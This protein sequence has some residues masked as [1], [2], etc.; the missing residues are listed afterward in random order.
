MIDRA[1]AL[2]TAAWWFE[3]LEPGTDVPEFG[4]HEFDEGFVLWIVEPPSPD[5][6]RPPA[7]VGT[8]SLVIDRE[9]GE[10]SVWPPLPAAVIAGR[11][12]QER[13]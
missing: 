9:T 7:S 5:P 10:L 12:R 8:A 11:Y 13:A 2:A 6:S 1:E 3:E 4:C